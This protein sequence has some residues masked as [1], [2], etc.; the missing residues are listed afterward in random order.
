MFDDLNAQ[1]FENNLPME[2]MKTRVTERF[3]LEGARL[4]FSLGIRVV[5][6]ADYPPDLLCQNGDVAFLIARE[7]AERL[8]GYCL[9]FEDGEFFFRGQNNM[10]YTLFSIPELREK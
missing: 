6:R 10:R 1:F 4:E 9:T 8:R 7:V 5:E 2:E 3:S